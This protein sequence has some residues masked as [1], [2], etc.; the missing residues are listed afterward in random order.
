M[1]RAR[2]YVAVGAALTVFALFAATAPV[3]DGDVWWIAR[4]GHD[5]LASG[6]VPRHNGYSFADADTPWVMHE[7]LFGPLYA[8]GASA[9]GPSFFALVGLGLVVAATA[10]ILHETV[11]TARHPEGGAALAIVTIL[12][13]GKRLTSPRPS[14]VSLLFVIGMMALAWRERMTWRR[15][16]ACVL[17]EWVWANAHGSFPLGVV[18]IVAGA[19][20]LRTDLKARLGT[21]AAA[22][23]VT[24]ANPYGLGLHRLVVSYFA[25]DADGTFAFIHGHIA[26]F[27]PIWR[28]RVVLGETEIV[29]LAL[30][31]LLTGVAL[32]RR[33][34][35]VRGLF[36]A[37]VAVLG[38]LHV[39]HVELFGVVACVALAPVL[40]DL[41]DRRGPGEPSSGRRAPVALAVAPALVVALV[42]HVV[43]RRGRAPEDWYGPDLGG[44]AFARI[45]AKIPAGAHAFVPFQST[46]LLLWLDAPRGVKTLYDARNDCYRRAVAEDA[47][48]L[49]HQRLSRD[50]A[51][52]RLDRFAVD[53]I[54]V[55]ADHRLAKVLDWRIAAQDGDW[56]LLE[57]GR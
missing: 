54:A 43:V 20:I 42:A 16:V 5:M 8:W 40:D 28:D 27:L 7:W 9:L 10:C 35:R 1:T 53:A 17:L 19:A 23:L 3:A 18:L 32:A 24:V 38:A 6:H 25:G 31:S 36:C 41:L 56:V 37:G 2:A 33:A 4:A 14:G 49:E 11:R 52:A 45:A 30:L 51:A 29:A 57:R 34:H 12:G 22:A 13:M 50:D 44:A 26:E 55:P 48:A 15:A 46:G 47:F 21:A 39:R